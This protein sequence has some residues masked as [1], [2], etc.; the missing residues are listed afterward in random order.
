[1][2]FALSSALVLAAAVVVYRVRLH[3]L[4]AIPGPWYAA[5]SS[6]FLWTTCYLGIEGRV[7]RRLHEKHA[8]AVLR[9]GPNSVSVSD[10]GAM[11]EIYVAGG[12]FPK[13]DRYRNFN[14]GPVETIFSTLD[15]AYRDRRAKAVA[16]LFSPAQIRAESGPRGSVGRHVD[17][18]VAQLAELRR[19]RVRTDLLDLCAKLS[20]DVVS[21]YL[22][23]LP[24]GGLTEHAH[25]SLPDR[26]T[27]EGK[28]SANEFVHAIV[29]F[30]RFSL[31]PNSLFKLTYAVSQRLSHSVKVDES[32]ARIGSFINSVMAR[33]TDKNNTD[34]NSNNNTN[35]TAG[36]RTHLYPDRLLAVGVSLPETAAQSKAILF[37]GAD[38]TAV[39]LATTLFHLARN[40]SAR[41]RLLHE[42]RAAA[43]AAAAGSNKQPDLVFLRACVKEGLRMC[44]ANPV[45]LT[46]VVPR[47]ADL[48]VDGLR[49]PP[50]TTVGCA[51]YVMHHDPEV[52]PHPFSF[53][54]ERWLDDGS[55]AGLRRPAMEKSLMPFGH[56]LRACLGK[57]LAMHQLHQAVAAVIDAEILD[58]ARTVQDEIEVVE[59]FNGDIKGHSVD[60]EW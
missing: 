36:S 48:H 59:W 4:R 55:S 42:I 52:F 2:L 1:M 56:G 47:A 22:L 5:A 46:R 6:L 45:R 8:T 39:A 50:G 51:A 31:L 17:S 49:I 30:A 58:G 38:S 16:P 11:H 33:V 34:N 53:K 24:Y 28:L 41:T 3:P 35:K 54:P 20:I 23:G 60:I 9:V 21:D 40:T 27:R 19:A 10:S 29:G 18:F 26:Q 12:G 37:A 13:D 25:L 44:M 32:L 7:M 14:L 43:A 15:G 57:N